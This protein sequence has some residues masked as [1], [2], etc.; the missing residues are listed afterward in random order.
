M[1]RKKILDWITYLVNILVALP[2]FG[3]IGCGVFGLAYAVAFPCRNPPTWA[4]WFFPIALDLLLTGL[5]GWYQYRLIF[6]QTP[7]PPNETRRTLLILAVS[8]TIAFALSFGLACWIKAKRIKAKR[9]NEAGEKQKIASI[10][11][12]PEEAFHELMKLQKHIS[13]ACHGEHAAMAKFDVNRREAEI[14]RFSENFDGNAVPSDGYLASGAR[15]AEKE[16]IFRIFREANRRKRK[17][18]PGLRRPD[19]FVREYSRLVLAVLK[20]EP[21]FQ[22]EIVDL[23]GKGREDEAISLLC[24]LAE[25][26]W[27][28]RIPTARTVRFMDV[29]LKKYDFSAR[30]KERVMKSRH[31]LREEIGRITG[32]VM[33]KET[34]R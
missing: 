3:L 1:N 12:D 6:R 18:R 32:I 2:V 26:E 5:W 29:L 27:L 34:D 22:Y 31:K 9:I 13:F 28:L 16:G 33:G 7:R 10:A 19:G 20:M 30:N 21:F 25:A 23:I 15:I 8:V 4:A 11:A 24:D 14:L 17:T